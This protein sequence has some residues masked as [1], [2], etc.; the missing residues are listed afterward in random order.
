MQDRSLTLTEHFLHSVNRYAEHIALINKEHCF[1][2][3][4]LVELVE[5]YTAKLQSLG[6]EKGDIVAVH[7]ERS[8]ELIVFQL[9]VINAGAIFLPVD[10]RYPLD[11]VQYL[12][13]DC[14]VS[15]FISDSLYDIGNVK[16]IG[17]QEFKTVENSNHAENVYN[18][19]I[20]YIIYTSGSTGKP[21][22][23]MLTGK[24]LVNFCKN[25]NTLK[26]LQKRE[27]NIFA[28]VN[29]VSFDYFI[30]ESLFPL[31]NGYTVVLLDDEESINQELFLGIVERHSINV[32]MTTP[33]RLKMFF[34]AKNGCQVLEQLDCICSSGEPLPPE[35]LEKLYEKSPKAQV[36][37][38]LGPSECT[39][40]NV[41]GN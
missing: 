4:E 26:T 25:N 23:C 22:G 34:D 33:T 17:L 7:L 9:A 21:K 32:V 3:S 30:A 38:P 39:V 6:I 2:Y 31:L 28:C 20:C 19:G 36:Y 10:K 14:A 1:T 11:R 5:D 27:D 35:L 13:Y 29:S 40:W 16:T 18:D 24:G 15:L 41:G 37:N 12:C 8:Y